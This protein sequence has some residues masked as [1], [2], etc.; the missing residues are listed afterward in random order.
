M[1]RGTSSSS[2]KRTREIHRQANANACNLWELDRLHSERSVQFV[3][4]YCPRTHKT[5]SRHLQCSLGR[6]SKCFSNTREYTGGPMRK[7]VTC[8]SWYVCTLIS[9]CY[10]YALLHTLVQHTQDAIKA[11]AVSGRISKSFNSTRK[12]T[13]ETNARACNLWELVLLHS[14][15]TML[16]GLCGDCCSHTEHK[17]TRD[18]VH[19]LLGRCNRLHRLQQHP[20]EENESTGSGLY[21]ISQC[22]YHEH[23]VPKGALKQVLQSV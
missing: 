22:V 4:Y 15:K 12:Y 7:H 13:G 23:G 21:H 10:P 17:A 3:A 18:A 9:T 5:P 2:L 19:C 16:E 1:Q 14:V 11:S 20:F 8:G 6:S